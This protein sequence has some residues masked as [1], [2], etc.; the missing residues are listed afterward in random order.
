MTR[1]ALALAL[2][3]ALAGCFDPRPD[4]PTLTDPCAGLGIY[5]PP[6]CD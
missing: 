3:L 2:G 5:A 4:A 6:G 1:L